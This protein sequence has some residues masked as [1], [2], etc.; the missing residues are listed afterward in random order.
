MLEVLIASGILAIVFLGAMTGLLFVTRMSQAAQQD[1][2]A[3]EVLDRESELIRATPS[4]ASL[5]PNSSHRGGVRPPLPPNVVYDTDVYPDLSF[6]RPRRPNPV[7]DMDLPAIRYDPD[8]GPVFAIDYTW[9]GFGVATGGTT[10]SLTFNETDPTTGERSWPEGIDFTGSYV[11]LREGPGAGQ[12]ARI[13][14]HT[15]GQFE[16]NAA[17]NGYESSNLQIAPVAGQTTFEVDGGKWVR[18]TARWRPTPNEA[19][20]VVE[21]SLFVSNR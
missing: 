8:A 9:Y 2:M 5:G 6:S 7:S 18:I 12:M 13:T 4:Y 21:R 15:A 14:S 19:E 1:L 11:I 20:R 16:L 3:M 10:G 17:F